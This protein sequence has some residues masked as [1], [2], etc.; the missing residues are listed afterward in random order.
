MSNAGPRV[1]G[2]SAAGVLEGLEMSAE[3]RKIPTSQTPMEFFGQLVKRELYV[4]ALAF[5]ARMLPKREAVW[6]G[7]L[8]LEFASQGKLPA[9]EE[10]ALGAAVRWVIEPN[11]TNRRRAQELGNLAKKKSPAGG[12]A[13][14]AFWS[15][16]NISYPDQ[17]K[18]AP[19]PDQ[20]AK[21]VTGALKSAAA[22][23]GA[24]KRLCLRQFLALALEVANGAHR[25]RQGAP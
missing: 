8:C 9:A 19:K 7:C 25:W 16:G 15:E 1:A 18:V 21:A 17:P 13:L 11:E 24:D 22:L 3:A 5:A 2:A 20:A 14:A 23:R 12:L 10:T 4:D 6:W